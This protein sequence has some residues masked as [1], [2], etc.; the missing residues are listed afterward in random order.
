MFIVCPNI[1]KYLHLIS[2]SHACYRLISK[3]SIS[4]TMVVNKGVSKPSI[5][6]T[7]VVNKGV[8]DPVMD[9]NQGPHI[10]T[11][12]QK[13]DPYITHRLIST[14]DPILGCKSNTRS[15]PSNA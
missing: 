13:R 9:N 12:T 4:L 1:V 2:T 15:S 11:S 10:H 6:L 5:S 8:S 7:M 3:P 14:T